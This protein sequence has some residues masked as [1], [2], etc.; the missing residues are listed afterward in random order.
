[1]SDRNTMHGRL[2]SIGVAPARLASLGIAAPEPKPNATTPDGINPADVQ[3]QAER[4]PRA[5]A[6]ACRLGHQHMAR[7]SR[8]LR[9]VRA[10]THA[11]DQRQ[12]HR[13]RARIGRRTRNRA[14][15][16]GVG[17]IRMKFEIQ[18]GT[19]KIEVRS[20]DARCSR[21]SKA[22]RFRSCPLASPSR[23]TTA[24]RPRSQSS[25]SLPAPSADSVY[26]ITN[27]DGDIAELRL[28]TIEDRCLD[29]VGASFRQ[30]HGG[31][32]DTTLRRK[33]VI[34]SIVSTGASWFDGTALSLAN[35]PLAMYGA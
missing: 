13:P 6:R 33:H 16:R 24:P 27:A 15:E 28:F 26:R 12:R 29:V 30:G 25:T 20:D 34:R 32:A 17:E 14:A 4:A 21:C 11:P 18:L 1:M 10:C 22:R 35:K 19:E 31:S 3:K 8:R 2:K 5:R 9:S 23:C 7:V